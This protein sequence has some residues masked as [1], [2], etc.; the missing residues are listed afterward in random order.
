MRVSE[1]HYDNTG[2]DAG[3]TIEISGPA[4]TDL[5]GWRMVL[6]NGNG[7][8][9]YDT[10]TLPT[11]IPTTC[12]DRGVVVLTYPSNGIQNGSADGLAL[13]DNAGAVV[14]F[15][16][17]EGTFA[18]V[19]GPANG[20]TSVDIGVSQSGSEPLG[21]SLQR[22]GAD[23][24][25]ATLGANTFGTCNDDAEPPPPP[26]PPPLP[27]TRFSELHYDNT[28][29]DVIESIEI[30]GPAGTALDGWSVVLYTGSSGALYSTRALSGPIASQCAGRGVALLSYPQDGIQNGS[31]DGLA[32]VDAVG[33]VVE[34]LSYEGTMT[35]DDGP[36]AGR[37]SIDIGVAE[38]SSNPVGRSLQRDATGAWSG[39]AAHSPGGCNSAGPL[40]V[41]STIT[42][43]G[44]GFFDPALPVGFQDQ[45][46]ATLRDP[47]GA[48]VATTFA[49]TVATPAAGA[50]DADGVVTA[51]AAGSIEVRATAAEGTTASLVLPTTVATP[52]GTAV[53]EGN[54]EFGE[55]SDGDA[56]DDF[57]VR[58]PQYV[59]SYN[60]AR[61]TPNW[62]SY[63]LEQT[64]FGRQDRCDC[65]TFDPDLPAHFP[66][67]TTAAYTGAGAFHGFGI[68]R[69]H[70]ARS[71]DRTAG[72]LDNATTFYFTN[73][74]PQAADM[75]RGP[76][77]DLEIQLGDLARLQNREVYIIAGV[78]GS[79][80]TVKNEGRI[81]IPASVWK[82]ALILPRDQGLENVDSHDDFDIVAVIMP[83]V[84]GIS[85]TDWR[86]YRTTVDGVEAA[87]GY[88][89]LALLPDEI[90]PLVESGIGDLLRLVDALAA[91]G[92][93]DDGNANAL[94]V[95]LEAALVRFA[96]GDGTAGT[97]QVRA[98]LDQVDALRR[99]G[100]LSAS[101]AAALRDAAA[102][103]VGS[104][105]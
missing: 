90:E 79:Q 38:S 35:A 25:S 37:T 30:E 63:N 56:G 94:R 22:S 99:A 80:G 10:D 78:A 101:D 9:A 95:K 96:G 28:G 17:Y 88:D 62:V 93:L 24:W 82:V 103:V 73:I 45:V 23:T 85:E 67:Y 39:P 57:I 19:G 92:A 83:N 97:N 71:F 49:W 86:D 44:R 81:T 43:V 26:P 1:L 74:V 21:S 41:P 27:A 31:P 29:T 6:Y 59:A 54:A 84:A 47:A 33:Q 51:L 65:F 100:R 4:E 50:V 13:V 5:S 7:G 20:M 98:F 8:A 89:V 104:V 55:P 12:G 52:S 16:S 60:V 64:H 61:G 53:Y 87:S 70:L 68:D 91:S 3:E 77:A 72:S 36:A 40:P 102:I 46:F 18:A 11:P 66:R 34:F 58:R 2:T 48:V 15:L 69:G 42:L 105:P 32:L 75:N 14:E 76:W